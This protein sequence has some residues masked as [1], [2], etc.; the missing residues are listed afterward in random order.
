MCVSDTRASSVHTIALIAS[1]TIL[2]TL[3]AS[4]RVVFRLAPGRA[5]L[6][7][8]IDFG[9]SHVAVM[10]SSQGPSISGRPAIASAARCRIIAMK[11]RCGLGGKRDEPRPP[12]L[13]HGTISPGTSN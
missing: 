11:F 5:R 12:A 13:A 4:G 8:L 2:A 3:E 9:Q 6:F 10:V 1:S 7:G